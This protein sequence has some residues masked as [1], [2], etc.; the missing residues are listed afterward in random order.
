MYSG[1]GRSNQYGYQGQ[2]A[3]GQMVNY[4]QSNNS[5]RNDNAAFMNTNICY[6]VDF[7]A[8]AVGKVVA[9]SKRRIRWC[10]FFVHFVVV[11][12]SKRRFDG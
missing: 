3:G 4:N 9:M 11:R 12:R 8:V 10:V 2:G 1:T 7:N 5:Y 6:Q